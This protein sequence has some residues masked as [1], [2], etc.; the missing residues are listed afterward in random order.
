MRHLRTKNLVT[1]LSFH[2]TDSAARHVI[3]TDGRN[4]KICGVCASSNGITS[5]TSFMK[6]G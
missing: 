6:I 4:F 2:L 1:I 3:N 5:I